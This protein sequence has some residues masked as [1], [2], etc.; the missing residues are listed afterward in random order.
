V[1][2]ALA[3]S[4]LPG[5]PSA[6]LQLVNDLDL[7]VWSKVDHASDPVLLYGNGGA[8]AD[9]RNNLETV[10]TSCLAGS[11]LTVAVY[12]AVVLSPVQLYALVVSGAIV[13]SS[14]AAIDASQ[15]V[16][17]AAASGRSVLVTLHDT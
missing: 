6:T 17:D 3:W 2:V 5:H 14:L 15:T 7:L 8:I 1:Q 10:S 11:N 9:S 12:G 16:L 4:D 13:Q